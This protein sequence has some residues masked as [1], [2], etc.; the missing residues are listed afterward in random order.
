VITGEAKADQKIQSF[1]N[2]SGTSP[3]IPGTRIAK[4]KRAN[5]TNKNQKEN[6]YETK[7]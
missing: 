7:S 5:A 2:F 3:R 4:D 6:I 1:L